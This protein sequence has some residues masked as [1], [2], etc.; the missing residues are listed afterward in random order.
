MGFA[1]RAFQKII[2]KGLKI[3][4]FGKAFDPYYQKRTDAVQDI[5]KAKTKKERGIKWDGVN[6]R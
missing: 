1:S 3:T 6:G 2:K 4:I 5:V